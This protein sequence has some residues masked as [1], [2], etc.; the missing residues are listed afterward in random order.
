[1]ASL[2]SSII[3]LMFTLL[4]GFIAIPFC[5]YSI[6]RFY[7]YRHDKR[8]R[9]RHG[10][11]ST[12]TALCFVAELFSGCL[13]TLAFS[14]YVSN[15]ITLILAWIGDILNFISY[16]LIIHCLVLRFWCLYYDIKYQLSMKDNV[17]KCLIDKNYII[18]K[19]HLQQVGSFDIDDDL[20]FIKNKSK[21]GNS[22]WV[23]KHWFTRSIIAFSGCLVIM[24]LIEA[25]FGIGLQRGIIE[26]IFSILFSIPWLF[27]IYIYHKIPPFFDTYH[28]RKEI[29]VIHNIDLID[30]IASI[31]VSIIA[32]YGIYHSTRNSNGAGNPYSLIL[33]NEWLNIITII[34]FY[35][36]GISHVIIIYIMTYWV[37]H[38]IIQDEKHINTLKHRISTS[39][40]HLKLIEILQH[41]YGY[42]LLMQH[43]SNEFSIEN[44]LSLTEFIQYKNMIAAELGI[45]K[46]DK[47]DANGKESN[48]V[49]HES[50][51]NINL[52]LETI[53]KSSIVYDHRGEVDG[54][55]NNLMSPRYVLI[56]WSIF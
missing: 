21:Q 10:R 37:R 30:V 45:D 29:V 51:L 35:V 52:P 48:D 9:K 31:M 7:S 49:E 2:A 16:F 39:T 22:K 15:S 3:Y 19:E 11:L 1:M 43:L 13:L 17:W 38:R 24:L 18:N 34:T 33:D 41:P 42:E 14:E 12:F 4:I 47:N 50:D 55:T 5:I 25:I 28:I 20:W 40:A 32:N 36:M 46:N 54:Q 44:L 56:V 27:M 8:F 53:P 23:I 6:I 26:V